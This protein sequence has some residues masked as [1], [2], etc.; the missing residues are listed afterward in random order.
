MS[1]R[2]TIAKILK[3]ASEIKDFQERKEYLLKNDSNALRAILKCAYDKKL[4]F[5]LPE[6]K[7]P[8]K[9]SEFDRLEGRIH[10]EVKKF[11]LYLEGGANIV[12]LKREQLFIDMM[13]S[14]D[15][16][17]AELLVHIKDKKMPYKGITK[18]LVERTYPG[19]IES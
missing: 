7:V 6:G 10:Q 12:Q 8:Y 17:D 13:E 4:K 2:I 3:N 16:E 19:L 11:Y 1:S 5:L 18:T 15:P 9:P 14:I